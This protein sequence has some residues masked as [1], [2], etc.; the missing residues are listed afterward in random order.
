MRLS[1]KRR[2][3]VGADPARIWASV[4][5]ISISN[6]RRTNHAKIL[7]K[8]IKRYDNRSPKKREKP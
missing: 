4:N 8:K 7:L 5:E 1:I 6:E 3:L 2:K